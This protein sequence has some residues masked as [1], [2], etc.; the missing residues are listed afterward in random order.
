M[1]SCC[2]TIAMTRKQT[3]ILIASLVGGGLL[4][5][6]SIGWLVLRPAFSFGIDPKTAP[7]FVTANVVTLGD[8][9]G[10]SK[11]RSG[12]GHDFSGGG[13]TCRSMKH[14]FMPTDTTPLDVA[15]A[16]TTLDPANSLPIFSPV[17][18]EITSITTETT[19]LGK[20][21]YLRPAGNES[22]TLRLFHVYP[23]DTLKVGNTVTAGERIGSAL[24][25]QQIDIAAQVMTLSGPQ[26]ISYFDV[27]S[28]P[29]LA[30]YK[31]RGAD[32]ADDFIIPR[33][34]RD[35]NPL[36]CNGESFTEKDTLNADH[37]YFFSDFTPPVYQE[38]TDS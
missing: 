32:S 1:L 16:P 26:F 6:A 38:S 29:V 15:K 24:R 19:P 33:D 21:I 25:N 35:A 28:D 27:M 4:L 37:W 3:M 31:D 2:H 7:K 20:Q 22:Y 30:L 17:D 36:T 18:G 8:Y 12:V 5:V 9:G 13:E 14:Y 34:V 23:L 11:F 10:V